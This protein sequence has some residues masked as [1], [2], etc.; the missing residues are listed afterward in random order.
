MNAQA[1]APR[2]PSFHTIE[3]DVPLTWTRIVLSLVSYALFF[4]D[5]PRSGFGVRQLPPRTF[6]PVTESLLA[7]FGPYNYSVIALSKE[8]NGSLTGPSV[9]P[10]W[11]YKFDT[12]SMGLRGIVEHFRVPFWDPCLLYKCPCGSDVVAPSTVYRMLDSLVDVVI[13]LRHRVTLRVE[14]RSVDKIYD[15]IAPTRA[16]VERDLRSVEVYAMTSP[17]DVC[18][19]NFSDA[20]F[21]CQEPWADFYALARFAAQLARIDPTTQVVDMA[22]VHSAADARHWGGGVARLLSFGVDVTTILRVQNCTNVLQKTT[23]STVEIE[24]YRYETAFIRTN[25]EGHYAITRVLRLVGQLYN[26]GRVLLLLVGCYVARTADP[27]FHGQHY[28]RQLWA[29]LR[30]FLRI[31]SQVIIYGS[32]LPVSMFAMAHLIDCPVV[33]I[34][35]FRAFSS[36]N[37]TF[38]VTH[39]AILD[40]LTVLTCQM[41]NVWLLSLWTKTQ[42]LPRRHVV[43]GY[44][45]Y[46]VP[47]VAFISLGFGIRLLSLRNV[48]VVAHTQVAPSAIVSAIRQLESVPPNY[49]YWGVYLDLRCLSMALILLHVLAYVV[50]GH[51]LK[52]ATQIPHMAAAACNPTMFSTSWSSLWA[53]APPSVISPTDV[54]IRCMDRRRS[55]NVLI[56]IAWMTD[57]IEYIYQSFAPATVFIYAYTPALPTASMV[58]RCLHGTATDAIVLHPWSVPKLKADCPNVERLLRIERQATLLSLSWRDRIYCC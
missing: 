6:A 7:Y 9:A 58:Y 1:T 20:P 35:V 30:T 44:R 29:V 13:S 19:E 25:V 53:N 38:S 31:P 26:I 22:V 55:E 33:Y 49:R 51:G 28:L 4:T 5:I 15:A 2:K 16:L 39:D 57:P 41:R 27:G 47:L 3:S 10:V 11:S 18:A 21:V 34:F 50:S 56:N 48:D 52:R 43:E 45:G 32:W 36:L 54:G 23:C 8:S 46:V 37:G 40:L 12:T 14:C 17:I 42:V 24:D